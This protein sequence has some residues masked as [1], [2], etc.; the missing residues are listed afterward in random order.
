MTTSTSRVDPKTLSHVTL[1]KITN[2]KENHNGYQYK[3]GLNVLN[4]RF[5]KYKSCVPG[6]LYFASAKNILYYLSYGVNLRLMRLDKVMDLEGFLMVKDENKYRSNIIYLGKPMSLL[7]PATYFFLEE[8]GAELHYHTTEIIDHAIKHKAL[9]IIKWFYD[10]FGSDRL[11][12]QLEWDNLYS[13]IKSGSHEIFGYLCSHYPHFKELIIHPSNLSSI[14]G[15]SNCT[16]LKELIY[17]GIMNQKTLRGNAIITAL[18][19]GNLEFF[20]YLEELMEKESDLEGTFDQVIKRFISDDPKGLHKLYLRFAKRNPL[21][22][23]EHIGFDFDRV[24]L[25]TM[26]DCIQEAIVNK[27]ISLRDYLVGKSPDLSHNENVIMEVAIRNNDSD[28]VFKL[29]DLIGNTKESSYDLLEVAISSQNYEIIDLLLKHNRNVDGYLFHLLKLAC[30]KHDL[31]III[32]A[33]D[34]G[35]EYGS[36][37]K[38]IFNAVASNEHFDLE[39]FGRFE[40]IITVGNITSY[41]ENRNKGSDRLCEIT[42]KSI[43]YYM[44]FVQK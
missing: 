34:L 24:S 23:F 25:D 11:L 2:E 32:L 15:P 12:Q 42:Q 3:T 18:D 4:T 13:V 21:T 5:S 22:T 43:E 36:L 7:D 20:L 41:E 31:N 35:V 38:Y 33:L 37:A 16:L 26:T 28:L 44:G 9:A 29:L 1:F 30:E 27:N 8:C 39:F 19:K 10:V 6:G 40:G 17:L 14:V